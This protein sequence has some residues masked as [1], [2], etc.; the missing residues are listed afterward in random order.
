[1]RKLSDTQAKLLLLA[2]GFLL[3]LIRFYDNFDANRGM[4][5]S[6][7]GDGYKAYTVIQYHVANDS[8]YSHY[9]GMN[10][11]YGEHVIPGACQPILSNTLK[12]ISNNLFEIKDWQIIPIVNYSMLL[13]LLLCFFFL[14]SIFRK[15]ELPVWYGIILSLAMG[16]LTPQALRMA[17][18]YG[19][20]HPEVLPL[21]I[22]LLMNYDERPDFKR[23]LWIMLVVFIYSGI[24]FYF[25]AILAFTVAF[26]FLFRFL[27]EW[28]WKKVPIYA[29]HFS[30]MLLVP[31]VFFSIWM[32]D[33]TI[34][35]R[36]EQPWGFFSYRAFLE[37]IYTSPRLA[38]YQW[39][40][41]NWI[42]IR[43]LNVEGNN[44]VGIVGGLAF[45]VMLV[46]WIGS[47]F[48][49]PFVRLEHNRKKFL[50]HLAYATLSILIFSLGIPFIIPGLE[51]LLDYT[52]PVRQFRSIGRFA[53]LF[54]YVIN[55]LAFLYLYHWVIA[56]PTV[57]R[58]V[59]L[60]AALCLLIV[61]AGQFTASKSYKPKL[62]PAWE[63]GKEFSRSTSIDFEKYQATLPL[64]YYNIGS[65]MFW[66]GIHGIG[67]QH[68]LT[69]GVQENLPTTAAMLTRTSIGQTIKQ[70]QLVSEP[71]RPPMILEDYPN[72]KPLLAIWDLHMS[73]KNVQLYEHLLQGAT[74]LEEYN[75]QVRFYSLPLTSFSYRLARKRKAVE[76]GLQ[77][78]TLFQV[79]DFHSTDSLER[80]V[81]RSF[82][83]TS[84]EKN[85]LG[86][87]GFQGVMNEENVL[88]DGPLPNQAVE[89]YKIAF[90]MYVQADMHTRADL[91]VRE[92]DPQT[93][94]TL[95][96]WKGG[97]HRHIWT[98]D[99]NGWGMF[100]MDFNLKSKDS[101]LR[102]MIYDEELGSR[103]IWVD[104]L[105]IRPANT[106]VFNETA[107]YIW[108][109]NRNY[110]KK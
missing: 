109:N 30:V 60:G 39:I 32:H 3:I 100:E 2:L 95:Q 8:T 101:K 6:Q 13:S 1:M 49:E 61:D 10:Y 108:K 57:M 96:E 73:S 55:T 67:A 106:N 48:K 51:G 22:Y 79:Q 52:G 76:L 26:Y 27:S 91:I 82:D 68:S 63:K 28:D 24:H 105:L 36:T 33:P 64:P 40:D 41:K 85:Y 15:L 18:H 25:F 70:L 17:G 16:L 29:A 107:T 65:D 75:D 66:Y 5:I 93:G 43:A 14:F 83:E 98:F 90:W 21:I 38:M 71:Y 77:D 74:L 80:F 99:T 84:S 56:K 23:S 110:P 69:I 104:E 11:P 58:K 47:A 34:T 20:A 89:A 50:N 86:K 7:W 72:T 44:Y 59:V 78:S 54:Y 9:E 45:L 31:F 97:V 35:D 92:Y 88:F 87:G 42:D 37:G 4:V 53:W 94:A 46:Q 81:Y 19:L 62:I 103:P 12:F 102:V